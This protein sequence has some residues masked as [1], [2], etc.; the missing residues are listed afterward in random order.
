MSDASEMSGE[1]QVEGFAADG[2]DKVREVFQKLVHDGRETGAGVSVWR[3]GREVVRLSGGW[4]DASR[5]R[6]W[7]AGTLVQPYSLSKSFVTL[8]ALVAVRDGV[9]AL[10]EPV[11][12]HWPGYGVAGKDRTTL[13]HVLTHRAG[14]PRFPPEAAGLDLLDDAGLRESLA[15][16]APEYVPG[17]SLG[18][19]ALTYGHLVDGVLRAG[20][21]TTL[22][23]TFNEVV[24]PAL[25]LDAWFGV[26]DDLLER[27]ADLEYADPDWPRRLH[28]AP[29]LRIP[30]G[31]L[32]V[33]RAN[34]RA[35]RQTV[36]GAVNL[37]T[38]ATAMARFFSELTAEDGPVGALLGPEL[39]AE[40]L[41]AQVTDFDEV[42]GTRITWTLGFVRD[43]GKIAKGGIGGSAAWWS[44][45]H[46]HG[47][48]YLTRRLDDHSRAAEIAAALGDDLTV[49]GED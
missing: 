1:A 34:S 48:A 30:D 35:W 47:C 16:A 12:G 38:T 22:G 6:P 8:A 39:H 42:F 33:E 20:A 41:A 49:V 7:Q 31:T 25:G 14:Q 10:D 3:D 44:R 15:K 17:T 9:L 37:H 4:A 46:H 2:Y 43:H 26:P 21:G 19:H 5:R 28:A 27:V 23:E 45:R 36:F 32:D 18:E 24:R 29:W 11:A 40:L 13:R